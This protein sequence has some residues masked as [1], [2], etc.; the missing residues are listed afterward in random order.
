MALPITHGVPTLFF[1][2]EAYE[3]AD[4]NR[5]MLDAK[6]G[7]TDAEF[8]VEGDVIAVGPIYDADALGEL[9]AELEA[10]GLFYFDDFFELSGSW[11]EWLAVLVRGAGG[12]A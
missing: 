1:R 4:I 7:L 8:R 6:L 5:A 3:R 12:T 2:R 9:V 11:P 10:S